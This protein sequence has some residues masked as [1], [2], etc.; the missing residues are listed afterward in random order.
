VQ[1][2]LALHNVACRLDPPQRRFF[3]AFI[4][5][6]QQFPGKRS[7]I[8]YPYDLQVSAFA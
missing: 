8:G 4:F 5:R 7:L 6:T 3:N 2:K 1:P